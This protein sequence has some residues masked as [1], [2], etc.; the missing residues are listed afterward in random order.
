[1]SPSGRSHRSET[2]G[3]QPMTTPSCRCRPGGRL[4]CRVL[5]IGTPGGGGIYLRRSLH[6]TAPRLRPRSRRIH[7]RAQRS[8]EPVRPVR[9]SRR[10][11]VIV[12]TTAHMPVVGLF[13]TQ[14]R[15]VVRVGVARHCSTSSHASA[16]RLRR[17][18][19][20]LSMALA[21]GIFLEWSHDGL[22]QPSPCV[23]CVCDLWD[24]KS[25]CDRVKTSRGTP[26][27]GGTENP[28]C[29]GDI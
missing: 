3:P 9:Q 29:A 20:T 28:S 15:L 17:C 16:R 7:S 19:S 13:T 5:C 12:A 25:P 6:T 10:T 8:S 11:A 18:T 21:S 27:V 23:C 2:A 22:V 1:M 14:A 26:L 4:L 24:D